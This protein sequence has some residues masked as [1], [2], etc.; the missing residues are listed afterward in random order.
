M[1]FFLLISCSQF[2]QRS[3]TAY[4][5]EESAH[6]PSN[7]RVIELLFSAS[8]L[9][10]RKAV[11]EGQE[12]VARNSKVCQRDNAECEGVKHIGIESKSKTFS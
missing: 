9:E 6:C 3:R 11:E 2:A 7:F 10:V 1:F 5:D 8:W 12:G 4:T